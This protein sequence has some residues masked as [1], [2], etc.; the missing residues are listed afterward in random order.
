MK[1]PTFYIFAMILFAVLSACGA[2]QAELD[3]TATQMAVKESASQTAAAPTAT[4]TLT[5]TNT[6][7]PTSTI[8]PTP[9][10]T[11]APSPT[12][13]TT[14]LIW[15]VGSPHE[16]DIPANVIPSDFLMA[17]RELGYRFVMETFP[18]EG[19]AERFIE[20]QLDKVEPDILAFVSF[21][22]INGTT[23]DLGNFAGIGTSSLVFVSESFESL[24]GDRG[25]WQVIIS[26]SQH[27]NEVRSLAM[28]EAECDPR[29]EIQTPTGVNETELTQLARAIIVAYHGS[30][31]ELDQY[32]T[33]AAILSASSR[34]EEVARLRWTGGEVTNTAICAILGGEK[35]VFIYTV[36]SF[37][38]PEY[39]GR[40]SILL[41]MQ[42]DQ[43]GWHV[44]TIS[45][46]IVTTREIFNSIPKLTNLLVCPTTDT[47]HQLQPAVLL[48]PENGRYPLPTGGDFFGYFEWQP[49]PDSNVV[50]EV[51]EFSWGGTSRLFFRFRSQQGEVIDNVSAG[52]L[53]SGESWLWR[54]W[55]ISEDCTLAFSE[56][57][58]FRN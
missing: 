51:A 6:V 28:A 15:K 19:F 26:T 56:V 48:S 57:R 14:I 16:G 45:N 37:E 5:P 47:D 12:P 24:E 58:F 13:H 40:Q 7:V 22:I 34:H 38:A 17:G 25:G 54:I 36:A 42:K 21:G 43:A 33:D 41:V 11:P 2:S 4:P 50:A 27:F 18:A 1:K 9:T 20:A 55:S 23:T 31:F 44:V 46:D 35:L 8:T 52:Q 49:S 10:N 30:D 53:Y 29:L 3:V 32:L 39:L